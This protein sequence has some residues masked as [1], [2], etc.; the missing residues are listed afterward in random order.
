MLALEFTLERGGDGESNSAV[1]R[2]DARLMLE[3]AA[4]PLRDTRAALCGCTKT[5][6]APFCDGACGCKP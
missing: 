4:G 1:S 3:T 6:N 5:A 2:G